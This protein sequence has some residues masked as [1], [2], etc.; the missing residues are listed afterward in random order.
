[1]AVLISLAAAIAVILFMS[2]KKFPLYISLTTAAIVMSFINGRFI[3]FIW[4]CIVK[5][6]KDGQT[7]SM[8][9]IIIL[10]TVLSH[11]TM[12]FGI[13]DKM[14]E[15]LEDIVR[16]TKAAIML[17]P[18][19]MGMLLITGGAY[20][21]CPVVDSLGDK[22]KMDEGHKSAVNLCFRHSMYFLM[23]LSPTIV[24]ASELSGISVWTFI[25]RQMPITVAL[26][27]AGYFT[28]LRGL[29]APKLPPITKKQYFSSFGTFW[30]YSLPITLSVIS[31]FLL[32]FYIAPAI[33]IVTAFII[34]AV[35]VQRDPLKKLATPLPKFIAQ[36]MNW[37]L[38][39]SMIAVIFFKHIVTNLEPLY[40]LINGLLSSNVPMEFVLLFASGLVSYLMGSV[41]P[42]VA[43]LYPLILPSVTLY[44]LKVFY[45]LIIYTT[46]FLFYYWSPMHLCQIV[47]LE[48]FSAEAKALYK[49]NYYILIICLFI[50]SILWYTFYRFVLL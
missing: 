43:L 14:V 26:F 9:V 46:G 35:D 37:K 33:G 39:L 12:K 11:V 17:A 36:G 44:S 16:S 13:L 27:I 50:V 29:A 5:T 45:A 8:V 21:S 49:R 30:V 7:Y 31:S 47:T 3:S 24:M 1:M 4:D 10:I 15:S 22:L 34:H 41:Q 23:P 28:L 6:V 38:V 18:A 20:I 48:Y 32:P 42:A 19:F 40:D 2:G 25:A